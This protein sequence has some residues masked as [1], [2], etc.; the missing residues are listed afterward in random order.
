MRRLQLS[1]RRPCGLAG[2]S[3]LRPAWGLPI[4]LILLIGSYTPVKQGSN[5]GIQTVLPFSSTARKGAFDRGRPATRPSSESAC[6]RPGPSRRGPW[7]GARASCRRL[8]CACSLARVDCSSASYMTRRLPSRKAR[9]MRACGRRY[10]KCTEG[11]KAPYSVQPSPM[12]WCNL[13][14]EATCRWL[15]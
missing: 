4:L 6:H 8:P 11:A 9:D 5:R 14:S 7:R 1:R 15:D 12:G 3:T 2:E 13:G 10:R